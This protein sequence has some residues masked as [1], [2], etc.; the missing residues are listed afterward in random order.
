MADTCTDPRR[1][2]KP[3]DRVTV[4]DVDSGMG[5]VTWHCLWCRQSMGSPV[6]GT[7]EH[8]FME[9]QIADVQSGVTAEDWSDD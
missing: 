1:A 4:I 9:A 2:G 6:P 8:A 3:H 7:D 5:V